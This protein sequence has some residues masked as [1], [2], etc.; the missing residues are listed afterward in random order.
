MFYY[1][2]IMAL[3]CKNIIVSG[4]KVAE[5]QFQDYLQEFK[6]RLEKANAGSFEQRVKVVE[7]DNFVK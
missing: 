1:H 7:K 4:F 2:N 3:N 5:G 6:N